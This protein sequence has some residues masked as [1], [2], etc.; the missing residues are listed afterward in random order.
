[1]STTCWPS[2]C[3]S[4]TAFCRCRRDRAGESPSILRRWSTT[5]FRARTSV[6][7]AITIIG[8][9]NGGCAAAADLTLRGWEVTLYNRTEAR[10]EPLRQIGGVAFKD[11]HDQGV[12]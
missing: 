6:S 8:A 9:G 12:V 3:P 11:P 7:D 2:P 10:L 1:M 4:R 5:R